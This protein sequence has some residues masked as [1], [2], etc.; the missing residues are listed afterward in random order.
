MVKRAREKHQ[1]W[2][3]TLVSGRFPDFFRETKDPVL[4]FD[5]DR[6]CSLKKT[7]T[8]PSPEYSEVKLAR[9]LYTDSSS[10]SR[11]PFTI[12]LMPKI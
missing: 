3:R 9:P 10:S 2:M 6:V 7:C 5:P 12:F 11:R 1:G 4:P 8:P